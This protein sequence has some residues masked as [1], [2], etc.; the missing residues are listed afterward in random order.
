[1]EDEPLRLYCRD[2]RWQELD[3]GGHLRSG[4]VGADRLPM[5][6]EANSGK[7]KKA[8]DENVRVIP[9]DEE[10]QRNSVMV[11]PTAVNIFYESV[12]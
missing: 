8:G 9:W 4:C 7:P 6:F 1:M 12:M 3:C 10:W 2:S 11:T 5:F